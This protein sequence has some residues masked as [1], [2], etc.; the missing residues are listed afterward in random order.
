MWYYGLYD[1]SSG[2]WGLFNSDGSARPAATALHNLTT[3]LA[4]SGSNFTPGSLNYTLSGTQAGDNSF[5]MEKSDGSFW[6]GLW[7]ESGSTHTVTVN[8]PSSAKS[9]S[10][11]DPIT[12][13][14]AIQIASNA[15]SISVKSR[16]RPAAHRGRG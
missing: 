8:L 12:G 4:D 5:L 9:I 15:S 2:T 16:Q 11:F 10:V 13:T 7:D 3:L 14:S 6:I 1:N